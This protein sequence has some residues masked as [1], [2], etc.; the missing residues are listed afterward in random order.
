MLKVQWP[1]TARLPSVAAWVA[2]W[3]TSLV[4]AWAAAPVPRLVLVSQA[5][6]A[7]RL[8]PRKATVPVLPSVVALALP[9]VR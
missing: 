5:Q 6:P 3:V 4:R 1:A 2:H 8:P 9:V 7:A